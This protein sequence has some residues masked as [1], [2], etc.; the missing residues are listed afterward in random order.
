MVRRR[1]R[2]GSLLWSVSWVVAVAVACGG[3][4]GNGAHGGDE[5]AGSPASGGGSG[6]VPTA[7]AGLGSAPPERG[8][9]GRG[10]TLGG[11]PGTEGGVP[12]EAGLA[13]VGGF[14]GASGSDAEGGAGGSNI[15]GRG[16]INADGCVDL[17]DWV[18]LERDFGCS[19]LTCGDPRADL[20]PDGWLDALD[21][22][23]LREHWWEGERCRTSCEPANEGGA[24]GGGPAEVGGQ[25]AT[26][27]DGDGCTGWDDLALLARSYGCDSSCATP[28]T[29][30]DG[31]GCVFI[32][33]A[34]AVLAPINTPA[35][36][37]EPAAR[38]SQ[39]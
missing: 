5:N 9:G 19:L 33:D 35:W 26:D 23:V 15:V 10:S 7:G 14:G 28:G 13:A 22:L 24:G 34:E 3:K 18:I 11:T 8:E 38:R 2:I 16:D 29:D 27:L 20:Q 32:N 12:G 21:E 1:R 36:C 39:P 25:P 17:Q 37:E 6:R 4:S 30:L 31:D